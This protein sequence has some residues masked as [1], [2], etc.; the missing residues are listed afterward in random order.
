MVPNR[1][2]WLV[3]SI[4]LKLE[5][6]SSLKH[7]PLLL[8]VPRNPHTAHP[9]Y[10]SKNFSRFFP[11]F[12]FTITKKRETMKMS[13][14]WKR[15]GIERKYSRFSY[16]GRKSGDYP[17]SDKFSENFQQFFLYSYAKII[18]GNLS[19]ERLKVAKI[20][21][22]HSNNNH[23]ITVLY[24]TKFSSRLSRIEK[25]AKLSKMSPYLCMPT[26]TARSIVH[27]W[28]VIHAHW[29]LCLKFCFIFFIF[30]Q[31]GEK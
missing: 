27:I 17:L 3:R 15:N 26:W 21:F 5:K 11:T 25:I 8:N 16:K 31:K 22:L 30:V 2:R 29:T 28:P 13:W 7:H 1:A 20:L 23:M 14:K 6:K 4:F 19:R 10:W 9:I 18:V 24:W 12:L